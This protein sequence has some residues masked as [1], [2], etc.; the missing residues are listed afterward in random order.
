MSRRSPSSRLITGVA[1][2]SSVWFDGG[3][4]HRQHHREEEAPEAC[5]VEA[6]CPIARR[7]RGRRR[8]AARTKRGI[9]G[10]M[11]QV[12]PVEPK[13]PAPRALASNEAT[14]RNSA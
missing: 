2:A 14:T 11:P 9:H 10:R 13:P 1:V 4:K 8:D 12:R 6:W 7:L 3:E 5:A